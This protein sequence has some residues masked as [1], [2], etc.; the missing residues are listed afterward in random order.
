MVTPEPMGGLAN[1]AGSELAPAVPMLT[2]KSG[3]FEVVVKILWYV[4][5][6]AP[7]L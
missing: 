7:K 6:L 2:R 4:T 1:T 5:E 3:V